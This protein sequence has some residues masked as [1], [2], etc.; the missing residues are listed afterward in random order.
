MPDP[1]P[2]KIVLGCGPRPIHPCHYKFIDDSWLLTDLYP[3][4]PDIKY[5]DIRKLPWGTAQVDTI[6]ASHVLEHVYRHEIDATLAEWARALKSGGWIRIMVP[7]MAWAAGLI[8]QDTPDSI[9]LAFDVFYNSQLEAYQGEKH[10]CGFTERMLR[11]KFAAHFNE[12]L[13][14]REHETHHVMS[15]CVEGTR[16]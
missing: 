13:F 6:Y 3:D 12:T 4:G 9:A 7:D 15:I 14:E 10:F 11:G 16:K 5:V 8:L 1:A 2:L